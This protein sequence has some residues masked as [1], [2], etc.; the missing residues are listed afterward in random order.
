M[1]ES[2]VNQATIF[3]VEEGDETRGPLVRNLRGDGLPRRRRARHGRTH[4]V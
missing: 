3:L 2:R 4:L 1:S